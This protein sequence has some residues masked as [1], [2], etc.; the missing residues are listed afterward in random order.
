MLIST[1]A[2]FTPEMG[3]EKGLELSQRSS[4]CPPKQSEFSLKKNKHELVFVQRRTMH[5]E[6][7]GE[8]LTALSRLGSLAAA[9]DDNN[10]WLSNPLHAPFL[11][12]KEPTVSIGDYATRCV[13]VEF[14]FEGGGVC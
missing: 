7:V 14:R 6:C 8:F 1:N 5:K 9:H 12:V 11:T 2:K 10:K 4:S 3:G 13:F